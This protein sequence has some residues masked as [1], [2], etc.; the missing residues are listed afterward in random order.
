MQ[1]E[2]LLLNVHDLGSTSY[3]KIQIGRIV[4]R[5]N[6]VLIIEHIYC[7]ELTS[8]MVPSQDEVQNASFLILDQSTEKTSRECSF[9]TRIGRSY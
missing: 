1:L 5:V 2:A 6:N 7:R 3:V 8:L 9:H 4:S